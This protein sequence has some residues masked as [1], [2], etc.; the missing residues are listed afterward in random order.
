V[1]KA[2]EA[3]G[4]DPKSIELGLFG[5]PAD[6]AKLTSLA[7]S[8]LSRAVFTMPQGPRDEVLAEVERVAPLIEAMRD[9]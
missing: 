8:G 3:I 9:A 6:E 5:A 4:R 2:C 1:A 7:E